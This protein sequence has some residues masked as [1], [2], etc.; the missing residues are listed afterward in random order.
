[1]CVIMNKEQCLLALYMS[2]DSV[3]FSWLLQFEGDAEN[4]EESILKAKK[5][6]KPKFYA[7][8]YLTG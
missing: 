3:P 8:Q 4:T 6:T 7:I 5:K 1:M 2:F